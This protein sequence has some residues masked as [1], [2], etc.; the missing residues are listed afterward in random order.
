MNALQVRFNKITSADFRRNNT[1]NFRGRGQSRGNF[2]G[3][4]RGKGRGRGSFDKS[5]NVEDQ[6]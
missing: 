3:N 6:E 1:G 4:I 2:R 5:P